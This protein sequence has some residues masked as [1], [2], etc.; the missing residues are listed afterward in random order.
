MMQNNQITNKNGKAIWS[1]DWG[2]ILQI[3]LTAISE[4]AAEGTDLH[5]SQ[6]ENSLSSFPTVKIPKCLTLSLASSIN[7]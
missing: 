5:L 6:P 1:F 2:V 7:H 3:H 4:A